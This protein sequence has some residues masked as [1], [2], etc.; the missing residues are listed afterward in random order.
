M[1]ANSCDEV[2]FNSDYIELINYDNIE[3][4]LLSK[5]KTDKKALLQEELKDYFLKSSLDEIKKVLTGNKFKV[6]KLFNIELEEEKELSFDNADFDEKFESI[7][8]NDEFAEII[9]QLKDL[10]NMVILKELFKNSKSTNLSA[11]MVERYNTHRDDLKYLKNVFN[12]NRE[13][14]RKLFRSNSKGDCLYDLYIHNHKNYDEF[15]KELEKL[16]SQ[17]WSSVT[18][19]SLKDKY[20]LEIKERLE[21]ESFLPRITET[22]NG[23]FPYQLNEDELKIIIKNQGEYYPFLLNEVNGEY[24]IV[25]LLKFKIPYY[26]GPLV[27]SDRSQFAWMKRNIENVKITP[28]NFDEV[29]DK[30]SSAVEFIERMLGKCTYLLKKNAMANNSIIC[31]EYKVLNEL[32]QIKV[33]NIK[34]TNDFIHKTINELFKTTKGTITDKKF[35]EYLLSS[36]EYDMYNGKIEVTGYSADGKFANN[37]TSYVDFFG[38]EGFFKNTNYKLEDAEKIIRWITIFEDKD[39]LVSKITKEYPE[40]KDR[41]KEIARKKYKGWSNLSKE[42]LTTKYYV[43]KKTTLKKSI[44]D[45]MNETDENFMQI[46]NNKEYNFDEMINEIN[47]I[48]LN[49]TNGNIDYAIVDELATSP[50]NKR[51]IWQSILVVKE[52]VKFMGYEPSKIS[53]EMARGDEKKERKDDRKK[54]LEKIYKDLKGQVEDYNRLTN[55]LKNYEKIDSEK[56]FLY[57]IQEGKSLYS[58]EPLNINKLS[59]YEVDHII[60]RSLIKD[61]SIENKALV[62][63]K[64]NQDKAANVILPENYRTPERIKWWSTLI[65][66]KLISKKKFY[67]L[68]RKEYSKDDIDGF[69][70]RQLVETRQI[71]K[72]VANIFQNYYKDT[73][74]IYLPASLSHNYREKF[75]MF[76]YRDLNDYHHAHDAY[77][78]AVMGLYKNNFKHNVDINALKEMAKELIDS[79]QYKEAKYGLVINSLD[80]RFIKY[81]EAT[82]EINFDV[83]EFNKT[84][85]DTLY[86]NDIL[87]SKK[88]EI[89][90]GKFYDETIYKKNNIKAKYNINKNLP[91]NLYGGYNNIL[92]SYMMFV[93]YKNKNKYVETLVGVPIL[94]ANNEKLIDEYIKDTL[95]CFNYEILI[96]K[97]PFN[98]GVTYNNQQFLITGITKGGVEL[99]NNVQLKISK[100]KQKKFKYLFNFIFNNKYPNSIDFKTREEKEIYWNNVFNSEINELYYNIIELTKINYKAYDNII[101]KLA[102]IKD[103]FYNLDL[104]DNTK[105]ISKVTFIKEVFKIFKCSSSNE[106]LTNFNGTIKL[107]DRMSRMSKKNIQNNCF[108]NKSVTGLWEN[109]YE[110]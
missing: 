65:D 46:L 37:M 94:F 71:T 11:V 88:T 69:I 52:I 17:V 87:I 3:N 34:L 35:K 39:I 76:K 67:N 78:A 42:L 24:K 27:S 68:I 45:L 7:Q 36:G 26:V 60:P 63:R 81:N 92:S 98:I 90:T 6:S 10:Y 72:H 54:Y 104:L 25:K 77:L 57:F 31:C 56:L 48:D 2:G 23:T 79:K 49:M 70:N 83:E 5:T 32:K 1:I 18:D 109:K 66:K 61:D 100:E 75:E 110:L 19:Q 41:V 86:R 14:Y 97:I 103:E 64:E 55:E 51:G 44:L 16:L 58:G 95:N 102:L 29:I 106:D 96:N 89:R 93:K 101:S 73:K 50:S 22:N 105:N 30:E 28:Y 20:E 4:A 40:L 13:L 99:I 62:L 8:I 59:E 91:T 33:N 21:S 53:I 12:Y 9:I 43:D 15:K 74:I 84:V 47:S 107:S 108:K 38:N 82:G 80:Q 85:C